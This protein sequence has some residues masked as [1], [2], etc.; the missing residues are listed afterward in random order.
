MINEE[1]LEISN[2]KIK[3]YKNEIDL[4]LED[5]ENNLK[6][7]IYYF[8]TNNR[9]NFEDINYEIENKNKVI[10]NMNNGYLYV[11]ETTLNNYR[12]TAREVANSFKNIF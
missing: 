7:M 2:K 9:D 3:L 4:D 1:Q 11:L 8:D 12:E 6:N 5:I 10:N